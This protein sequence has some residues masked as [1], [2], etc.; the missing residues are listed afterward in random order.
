MM[1]RL[2]QASAPLALVPLAL[3]IIASG[4]GSSNSSNLPTTPTPN[5]VTE[6]FNGTIVQGQTAVFNFTITNSGYTLLA[7]YTSISPASV[8]A[9]GLG[10]GNWDSGSQ[11]CSLNV[12][13]NDSSHSGSTAISG[14]AGSGNFC[15]R[16]YDAGN[17][18]ADTTATFTIQVQHY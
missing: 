16:V 3:A 13:Q 4:C 9:L 1:I 14:T 6:T 15:V 2:R 7:G 11:T 18:P 17:V 12:T 8:T 5:I 10:I